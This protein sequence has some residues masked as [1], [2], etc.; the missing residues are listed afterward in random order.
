MKSFS[1]IVGFEKFTKGYYRLLQNTLSVF[2]SAE[3]QLLYSPKRQL[4]SRY[5]IDISLEPLRE[6]YIVDDNKA[7]V[8]FY[9][10]YSGDYYYFAV[11]IK[12]Y[13]ITQNTKL[14]NA[15]AKSLASII[16]QCVNSSFT[17]A[18]FSLDD[19]LSTEIVSRYVSKGCYN[20]AKI[21]FLIRYLQ[22]IRSTTFEGR[23]FSTGF[24]LTKSMYDYIG[25]GSTHGSGKCFRLNKS[26]SLFDPISNR[27]WYLI[28]GQQ[29]VYLL[30]SSSS[31]IHNVYIPMS[32]GDNP[33]QK[34]LWTKVLCGAD[35]LFKTENG[36]ECSIITSEGI[37]FVFQGNTW[38]YRNYAVFKEMVMKEVQVSDKVYMAILANILYCSKNSISSIIWIPRDL[39]TMKHPLKSLNHLSRKKINILDPEYSGIITRFLSSD[40]ATVIA[41][42]G[43]I[44]CFGC[45]VDNAKAK[46]LGIK[47]TGETAAKLLAQN[48]VSIKISQ[49][50]AIKL[51]TNGRDVPK[52]F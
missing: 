4:I 38:R 41:Q 43:D 27:V 33:I 48:G 45:I 11:E 1:Q 2:F 10:K 52:V 32:K 3:V 5:G 18:F 6:V 42:N 14:L 19:S 17:A 16:S 30:S 7:I 25:N 36:L 47:G 26:I 8:V 40:G 13:G 31:I 22:N 21:L 24:I 9:I 28:D 50:G 23:H 51:F 39:E 46:A 20:Q 35:L 34:M 15:A 44:K 29:S 49:D 37:E 12:A